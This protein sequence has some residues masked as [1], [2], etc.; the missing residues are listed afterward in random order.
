MDIPDDAVVV[1]S[2]GEP[3]YTPP[4]R[5]RRRKLGL[6]DTVQPWIERIERGDILPSMRLQDKVRVLLFSS[7][8]IFFIQLTR[9][10]DLLLSAEQTFVSIDECFDVMRAIPLERFDCPICKQMFVSRLEA[11]EHMTLEHPPR[12]DPR[13]LFCEVG[14]LRT[15]P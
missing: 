1:R 12:Q 6:G 2:T 10:Q 15:F 3:V 7:A 14:R 13:P 8:H 5:P 9:L 4:S 11:A